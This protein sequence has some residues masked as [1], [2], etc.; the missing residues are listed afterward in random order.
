MFSPD[1]VGINETL[2]PI[3]SVHELKQLL[4]QVFYRWGS[5]TFRTEQIDHGWDGV[6][7]APDI[8]VWKIRLV[9]GQGDGH[10]HI[11]H[12]ALLR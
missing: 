6:G 5:L 12:V 11:G 4:L 2:K 7:S 9:D 10:E 1:G 3:T 8:Y